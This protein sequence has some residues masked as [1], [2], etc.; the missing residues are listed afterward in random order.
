M[1]SLLPGRAFLL[2]ITD[3]LWKRTNICSFG[4]DSMGAIGIIAAAGVCVFL[5]WFFAAIVK[6]FAAD[7]SSETE[8]ID[9]RTQ[10]REN[11]DTWI[12]NHSAAGSVSYT[13]PVS[14]VKYHCPAAGSGSA[15]NSLYG[16][17]MNYKE[18]SDI[19]TGQAS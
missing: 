3:V 8:Y 15:V 10:H 4:G 12:R 9:L 18:D 1:F 2:N 14:A 17:C 19:W 7:D 6:D 11:A 16:E 13:G 5:I